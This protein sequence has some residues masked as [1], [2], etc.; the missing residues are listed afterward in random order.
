MVYSGLVVACAMS[1]AYLCH[2]FLRER[3]RR[4]VHHMGSQPLDNGE[5]LEDRVQDGLFRTADDDRGDQH[6]PLY[7]AV[8]RSLL[9]ARTKPRSDSGGTLV[10]RLWLC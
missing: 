8:L 2:G 5:F 9:K 7:P 3:V 1:H 4:R 6:V 10:Q